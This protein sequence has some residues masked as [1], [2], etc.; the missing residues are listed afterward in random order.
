MLVVL[1]AFSN[2]LQRWAVVEGG[3]RYLD[4]C[5]LLTTYGVPG[6]SVHGLEAIRIGH[7]F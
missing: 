7:S 3:E 2:V 6:S 4:T 5:D 1:T